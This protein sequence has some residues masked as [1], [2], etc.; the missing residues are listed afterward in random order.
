MNCQAVIFDLD[1]TLL[2]TL[3]D[4]ADSANRVLAS[5]GFAP[6]DREAYRWFVGDGSAILMTRA[7][8]E[9]RRTPEMIQACLQGFIADYNQNWHHATRPYDGLVDLL[10]RLRDL[11]IKL[12]VVTNKPHR[13]AG[14]M[15]A[16]YFG[17]FRFDPILGQQEGIPK[18]P[19]PQQALAAADQMAAA[20]SACIFIGDSAVDMD[21]ARRAGMQPVGAG[22]G[23]RPADEL[24]NAGASVVIRHPL[25]L[26]D[27][28]SADRCPSSRAV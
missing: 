13:F 24:L 19:N 12:S 15:M 11:Q 20:P 1:G 4:I 27:F 3:T 18:K 21:T 26:L 23:F 9:D 10:R 22:W 8:P 6:H 28:F 16:Y 5:H 25:E 14:A 17:G 7:L 2:D